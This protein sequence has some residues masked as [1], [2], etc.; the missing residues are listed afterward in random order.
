MAIS[1]M[2][3][4]KYCK[5]FATFFV[6]ASCIYSIAMY[7]RDGFH[8]LKKFFVFKLSQM[9]FETSSLEVVLKPSSSHSDRVI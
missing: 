1:V 2:K 8:K 6:L 7:P 9:D 3:I 5:E 4:N